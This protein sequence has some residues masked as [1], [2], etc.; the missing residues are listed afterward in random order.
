MGSKHRI[1]T[2]VLFLLA[3]FPI[4]NAEAQ[5]TVSKPVKLSVIDVAGNLQLSKPAI[6]A[7]KAANPKLVSDIEYIQLT[8]PELPSKIKAQQMAGNL[9]TTLVLTGYDAMASG[10]DQ[11]IYEQIMPKYAADFQKTIA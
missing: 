1:G 2:L 9:D 6:E 3:S 5:V 7:F 4:M 10:V 11:G 8:A